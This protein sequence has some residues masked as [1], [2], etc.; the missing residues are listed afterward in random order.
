M[1]LKIDQILLDLKGSWG[2]LIPLLT[3]VFFIIFLPWVNVAIEFIKQSAD[4][5]LKMQLAKRSEKSYV[6]RN[7][8]EQQLK[9]LRQITAQLGVSQQ[10]EMRSKSTNDQH[11][12]KISQLKDYALEVK[13]THKKVLLEKER[14]FD[15]SFK[16]NF[17]LR[18]VYLMVKS[19]RDLVKETVYK[20]SKN[21]V[22]T[23]FQK[24]EIFDLFVLIR[25]SWSS[26]LF[27]VK[28]PANLGEL[29]SIYE[30]I[31]I[32]NEV[33]PYIADQD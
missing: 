24:E 32:N 23:D 14:L 22:I 3:S 19:D 7:L 29:I 11:L 1:P 9:K 5:F 8:Y 12:N 18:E 27:D 13:K 31:A 25:K 4:S 2:V 33:K 20:V 15:W 17:F 16:A 26:T 6:S 10:N 21:S 30:A 28:S